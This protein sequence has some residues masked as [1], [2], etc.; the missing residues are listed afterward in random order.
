[1][2]QLLKNIEFEAALSFADQ[3]GYLPGQVTSKTL[4]Q[5]PYVSLTLFA[6][7]KGEEISTHE[8]QGDALVIAL[9]MC[10]RDRHPP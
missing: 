5:N 8:S 4:A 2:K 3:V 6:F 10:I 7:D 9:E 1:M